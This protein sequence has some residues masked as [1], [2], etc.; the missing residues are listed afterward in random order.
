MRYHTFLFAAVVTVIPT[1][2]QADVL[3]VDD[4]AAPGGDGSGWSTAYRFLQDA[5]QVAAVPA[6][7]VSEIRVGQGTYLPDR[8]ELAPGGT[9]DRSASFSLVLDVS[10][11]GGYAGLGAAD[12]D[13]RDP[14]FFESVLSGDLAGDDA[15]GF[16]NNAENSAHIVSVTDATAATTLDGFTISGGNANV[17]KPDSRGAGLLKQGGAVTVIDC[18]FQFNAA[19]AQAFNGAGVAAIGGT[20][21]IT[22]STF[23]SNAGGGHGG[24]ILL[25]SCDGVLDDCHFTNNTAA[26]GA[27]IRFQE[28]SLILTGS[29]FVGNTADA[30]GGAIFGVGSL[31]RAIDCSFVANSSQLSIGAVGGAIT[32]TELINTIFAQNTTSDIGGGMEVTG[33][34]IEIVNCVFSRNLATWGGAA[35]L[36]APTSIVNSTFANNAVNGIGVEQGN[37]TALLTNVILWGN[38][39]NFAGDPGGGSPGLVT[40]T[41]SDIEGGW[42]GVGNIDADPVFAQPGVDNLRLTVGSPCVDAGSDSDLPPDVYDLDGD[43]NT[44]EPL[45]VDADG[46]ARVQGAAVDMGAYEGED[47]LLPPA[48]G[49]DGLDQGE[50]AVLVPQ[51]VPFNPNENTAVIVT[52]ISGPDGAW[53][54]ATEFIGALH[55]GA[56]GYSELS[57]IVTTESSLEDGQFEALVYIP[58][59]L[60]DLG[61]AEPG[62]MNLTYFDEQVGNWALAVSGN[63]AAA[64]GYPGPIGM[65]VTSLGGGGLGG[66]NELGWYGVS[67]DPVL[68]RGFVVATVDHAGDF[69]VGFALC[70]ADCLQTPDGQVGIKDFLAVL[71]SWG[72][73]SPCDIDGNLV[74]GMT[75]LLAVLDLWGPCPPPAAAALQVFRGDADL[76]GDGRIGTADHLLQFAEWELDAARPDDDRVQTS[77]ISMSESTIGATAGR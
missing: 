63:T 13:T 20:I 43:G 26:I 75:D 59:N 16:V 57:A 68:Q 14:R 36:G 33:D 40:A 65:R 51:G 15:P 27:C 46:Q 10:L 66:I 39:T 74:V 76:D 6:N 19:P 34:S 18:V 72:T 73:E 67:W 62:S 38:G 49:A 44:T 47:Q 21:A 64:D 77:T 48:E 31:L 29:T 54:T 8:T 55:P 30:A 23:D 52:N 61:G 7:G 42:P 12:P 4:D 17:S 35:F 56:G 1:T 3:F 50:F 70:P 69:G 45:P 24:A 5:L 22:G 2:G 28:A 53:F 32:R 41:Y 37:A 71:A 9:G 60:A 11:R 25:S 58:F